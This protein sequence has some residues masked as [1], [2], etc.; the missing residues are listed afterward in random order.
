M[1]FPF[2]PPDQPD[3]LEK[4]VTGDKLKVIRKATGVKATSVRLPEK[5]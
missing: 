3:L 4:V 2:P 1:R 5:S